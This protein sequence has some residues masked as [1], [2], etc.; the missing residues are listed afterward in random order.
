MTI[1]FGAMAPPLH[2]QLGIQARRCG[3]LQKDADAIVRLKIRG[4]IGDA[5]A[6]NAERRLMRDILKLLGVS[7]RA[8]QGRL[9]LVNLYLRDEL[10][11]YLDTLAITS[12]TTVSGS[13]RRDF[14]RF[15]R[16][17]SRA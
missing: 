5:T 3:I 17:G 14:R 11:A 9:L 1:V 10:H 2:E 13:E 6:R 8:A 7:P 12:E 16:I 15:A 4:L